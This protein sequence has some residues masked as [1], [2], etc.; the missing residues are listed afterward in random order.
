MSEKTSIHENINVMQ[1]QVQADGMASI[2]DRYR[3]Q[4]KFRCSFCTRGLSCQLC[5]NGPC[6]VVPGKQER[7]ACGIDANGMVMRNLVHKTNLG[8]AAY[9]HHCREAARTLK[10]TAAGKAPFAIRDEAKLDRLAG[11]LGVVGTDVRTRAAGVADAVLASLA[12]GGEEE[13]V[14]VAKF[15]PESRKK[16]W[17]ELGIFPGG[18]AFELVEAGARSMTNVDSNYLSLA[19]LALRLG[20]ASTYGALV[21]LELIQDVLFGTPSPHEGDVDLGIIDPDYVNIVPNGHE[22]FMGAALIDAAR[23]PEVQEKARA[24]GAKGL[25]IVGSIETGQ[26]LLQRFPCD[27]VF[28]GLTGNWISQEYALATGGVDLF[29]M[30]MNCSL[31]NLKEYADRYQVTLIS[32]SRLVNISGVELH[33]DYEPEKAAEQAL[34]LVDLAVENFKR[35]QGRPVA[36]GLAKKR[37]L[38]GFSTE[39]VLGVLGG[40]LEPLLD[41]IR[42][43]DIRGVAALVSCTSLKN[44][45][46]DALNVQVAREL[47]KRDILVLSAGCG[48][49]ACQVAGLAAPEARELAGKGLRAVCA[50]LGIPPVLSFGTCTDTGRLVLLVTAVADALGVDPSRLPVAVT[51]PEYMEQKATIDA[52]AAV[53]FGLYT[54][55]SPTPPVTGAPDVVKLLTT[56]VEHLVGGKLALGDEAVAIA[57]DI[58]AHIERKRAG[59]G[60]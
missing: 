6:R 55:V 25:R 17:R 60:L 38:T 3:G 33:I 36:R 31:P 15:A 14:M 50:G 54:H 56:D 23:R 43:G 5:S 11:E 12:Q 1:E 10:A 37:I 4:E 51:A 34:E 45:P 27:D 8:L 53:A 39:A 32:V 58:A 21:P 16:V 46:H 13:S 20:I 59:L 26:E 44:G 48:N 2:A 18:P 42:R 22:P 40:G 29:A 35:R 24:A 57:D 9:T 49:A 41:V 47:I 19:K 7:G 30:D 28:V 52:F